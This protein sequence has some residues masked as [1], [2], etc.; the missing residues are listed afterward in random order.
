MEKM[1]KLLLATTAVI[2]LSAPAMAADLGGVP[3]SGSPLYSPQPMVSGDISAAVG[4]AWASGFGSTESVG[5][6]D[7]SARFALP[8][9]SGV[10]FEGELLDGGAFKSGSSFNSFLGLAHL[11]TQ[12]PNYAL[13]VFGGAGSLPGAGLW[14]VGLEGQA[15]WGNLTGEGSVAYTGIQS[16][17]A[18]LWTARLGGRY[19]ITPDNK[20]TLG[21]DYFSGEGD[22]AWGVD[23]SLEHRFTGTPW[24]G[25]VKAAYLDS[26]GDHVTTA[27]VGLRVSL[28]AAGSSLQSHDRAVPWQSSLGIFGLGPVGF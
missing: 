6:Y 18:T 3:E 20:L 19:Y 16:G 11:Y 7:T 15:Y 10:S 14:Q 22:D 8:V 24:S 26:D 2:A 5:A 23:G 1:R 9:V 13:G 12:S 25:F 4:G 27:L 21:V 28:D 17:D